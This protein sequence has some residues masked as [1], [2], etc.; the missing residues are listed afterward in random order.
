MPPGAQVVHVRGTA[1][2][3]LVEPGTVRAGDVYLILDGPFDGSMQIVERKRSAAE[4][5]GPL[6][7]DDQG[8]LAQGDTEWTATTGMD[9]GDATRPRMPRLEVRWATAGTS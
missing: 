6:S 5:P 3:V 2:E 9:T 1:T 7:D 4:A 8:R